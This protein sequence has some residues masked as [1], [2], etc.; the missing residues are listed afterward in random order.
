MSPFPHNEQRIPTPAM[1]DVF[2]SNGYVS[3]DNVLSGYV[4]VHLFPYLC[5]SVTSVDSSFPTMYYRATYLFNCSFVFL[6]VCIC[7]ICGSTLP[8]MDPIFPDNVL[9]GYTIICLRVCVCL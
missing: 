5:P 4:F 1:N 7:D 9:S 6:S 3:P 8:H 2:P